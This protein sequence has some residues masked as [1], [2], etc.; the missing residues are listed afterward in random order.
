MSMSK[1]KSKSKLDPPHNIEVLV[2]RQQ[3][4]VG[5]DADRAIPHA[6]AL[7]RLTTD[8]RA[9]AIALR[10]EHKGHLVL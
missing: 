4:V 1:F 7:R 9:D 8:K 5:N 10:L 2:V 6:N 3:F